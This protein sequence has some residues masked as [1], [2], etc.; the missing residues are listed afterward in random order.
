MLVQ[1]LLMLLT[2]VLSS[3][4]TLGAAWWLWDRRLRR[5]LE[6]RFAE[7]REELGEELGETIRIKVR[8]GVL[9]AVAA[10]P[11]GELLRN[12]QRGITDTAVGIVRGGLSSLL[13]GGLRTP[14]P[15]DV[16]DDEDG[17]E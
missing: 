6:S 11:S 4:L 7:L 9:D 3:A 13:G 10:I 2:A 16:R 14:R 5:R 17:E 1:I 12:T 8:Q 15:G